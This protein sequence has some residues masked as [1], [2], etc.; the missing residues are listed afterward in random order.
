MIRAIHLLFLTMFLILGGCSSPSHPEGKPLP[1]LTYSHLSPYSPYG[2]AVEVRQSALLSVATQTTIKQ[3]VMAPDALIKRY[4]E[5]RFLTSGAPVRSIFDIEKLSLKKKT[6]ADNIMGILSGA[7][8]D[9]YTMDL[10]IGIYPVY[11]GRLSDPYT[12]KIKRELLIPDQSSLAEK[13]V[14]Q[15]EFLESIISDIDKTITTFI[16]NMK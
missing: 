6:D 16:P 10:A 13:E 14:R 7:A 15:F 5:N 3:F 4:A 11:D 12:I 2:G 1:T 8:A 9:Y